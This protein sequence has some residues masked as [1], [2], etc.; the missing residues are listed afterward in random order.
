MILRDCWIENLMT[1][2][3]CCCN[4]PHRMHQSRPDLTLISISEEEVESQ[5]SFIELV[6]ALVRDLIR[7]LID[8]VLHKLALRII[9]LSVEKIDEQEIKVDI[10]LD[11][12]STDTFDDEILKTLGLILESKEVGLNQSLALRG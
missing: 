3:G 2:L 4:L 1:T 9:P 11:V 12:K 8:E 6:N 7:N 5:I 10:V